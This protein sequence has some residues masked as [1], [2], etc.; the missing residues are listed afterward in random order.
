[1]Q[2]VAKTGGETVVIC[3][4]RQVGAA[5]DYVFPSGFSPNGKHPV[6]RTF[7]S[8]HWYIVID[9]QEKGW[10]SV[11]PARVRRKRGGGPSKRLPQ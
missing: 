2:F 9:S 1:M 10:I 7:R 8:G 6:H 5:Y 4:G 3:D 11:A